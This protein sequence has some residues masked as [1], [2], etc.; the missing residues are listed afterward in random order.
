MQWIYSTN[1]RDIAV[2]IHDTS[3]VK[4]ALQSGSIQLSF[5]LHMYTFIDHKH[6]VIATSG[7]QYFN[8]KCLANILNLT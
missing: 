2:A 4:S 6:L 5:E 3:P 1:H 7:N 8:I